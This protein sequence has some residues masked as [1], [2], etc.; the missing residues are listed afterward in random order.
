MT[1][2]LICIIACY[3][4]VEWVGDSFYGGLLGGLLLCVDLLP[5][6]EVWDCGVL[7]S[8]VGG[9][10]E[11]THYLQWWR[12]RRGL[13][14]GF[15]QHF[16]EARGCRGRQ[17]V[18]RAH[19]YNRGNHD[20]RLSIIWCQCQ[21]ISLYTSMQ[22]NI[23]LTRNNVLDTVCFR[24][25]YNCSIFLSTVHNMNLNSVHIDGAIWHYRR[26]YVCIMYNIP[27]VWLHQSHKWNYSRR[28]RKHPPKV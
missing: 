22:Y 5:D 28:I 3:R 7:L 9:D 27:L 18:I 10:I 16:P 15:S 26:L 13:G 17:W 11:G 14:R 1:Q 2:F 23:Q 21:Q 25:Q 20:G 19:Q 6:P 8:P 12:C 24:Q 4:S